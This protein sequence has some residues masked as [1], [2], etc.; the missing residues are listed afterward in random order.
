MGQEGQMAYRLNAQFKDG[1]TNS[2]RVEVVDAP[3]PRL[4]DTISI[5]RHDRP[6]AM[7]VTAIWTPSSKLRNNSLVTVE[8]SEI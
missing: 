8:T 3:L 4:G 5:V 2:D 7:R 6:V 1:S